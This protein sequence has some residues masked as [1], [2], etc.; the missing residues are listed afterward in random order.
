MFGFFIHSTKN[1]LTNN[2]IHF[3]LKLYIMKKITTAI[4]LISIALIFQNCKNDANEKINTFDTNIITSQDE[5]ETVKPITNLE[6]EE[7][8]A[9]SVTSESINEEPLEKK[10]IKLVANR[11]KVTEQK[12]DVKP[13]KE[14]STIPVEK[15]TP[16]EKEIVVLNEP[17]EKPATPTVTEPIIEK[18]KTEAP[19][20]TNTSSNSKWLVPSKYKTMKNPTDANDKENLAIGKT[21]YAKHCASCHGKKGLGDGSKAPELKGDL[22]DFSSAEFHKQT[23]GEIFFRLIDGYEDMPSFKKKIASDEDRW[24]IVNYV[25]TLKK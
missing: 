11:T 20:N 24:L 22:G 15:E 12:K 4:A 2:A 19:S 5:K 3:N 8:V 16:T 1:I 10:E 7:I 17:N 9:N 23:D 14:T 6:S 25:R 18:P 21:L 13:I